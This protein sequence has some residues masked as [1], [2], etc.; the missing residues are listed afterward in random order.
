RPDRAFCRRPGG[1]PRPGPASVS[2]G[3]AGT[4]P[5]ARGGGA[6]LRRRL[7]PPLRR[8]FCRRSPQVLRRP[9]TRSLAVRRAAA[10]SGEGPLCTGVRGGRR[11]G[12]PGSRPLVAVFR[13]SRR[14]LRP[15]L[16]AAGAAAGLLAGGGRPLSILVLD[17]RG[18]VVPLSRSLSRGLARPGARSGGSADAEEEAAGW[19]RE[20]EAAVRGLAPLAGGKPARTGAPLASLRWPAG[21]PGFAG[22]LDAGRPYLSAPGFAEPGAWSAFFDWSRC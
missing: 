1:R 22:K 12:G 8:R 10:G 18:A 17:V 7:S 16:A 14:Q 20:M 15:V 5:A 4:R 13:L 6:H 2:R 21:G 11:P 19:C 3:L 9:D